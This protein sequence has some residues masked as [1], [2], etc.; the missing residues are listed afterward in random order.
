MTIVALLCVDRWGRRKF[1]ITGASLMGLSLLVLGLV[2]HYESGDS[3][4]NPCQEE[5]YCQ[6]P[7][8]NTSLNSSLQIESQPRVS[9]DSVISNFTT[10]NTTQSYVQFSLHGED[11]GRIMAFTALLTFVAAYGFSFGP[12]NFTFFISLQ[13]IIACLYM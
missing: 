13:I 1:L 3:I 9:Y 10:N 5:L 8:H 2:T 12:G 11:F 4:V 6:M 7:S